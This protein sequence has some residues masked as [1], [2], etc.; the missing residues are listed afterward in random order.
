MTE[1][2][3]Q[4]GVELML[5][6]MGTVVVFLTLLVLATTTMSSLVQRFFPEPVEAA[7]RPVPAA[8][9]SPADPRL[10]AVISAAVHHHRQRQSR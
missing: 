2:I 4:Q 10:A 3:V 1:N 9:G 5:F 7:P 8:P 6:G